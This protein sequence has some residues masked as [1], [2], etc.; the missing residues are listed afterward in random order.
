MI[1]K[2]FGGASCGWTYGSTLANAMAKCQQWGARIVSMSLGGGRSS[3][4]E[5]TQVDAMYTQ[6]NGIL[7]FAAAS[8]DGNSKI[9]YPAG[10][11]NVISVA[12][13]DSS[14]A[15][16]S[17]SNYNSDVELAAPGVQ[18]LSTYP[19]AISPNITTVA[20]AGGISVNTTGTQLGLMEGSPNKG[21]T[22]APID[23]TI[24]SCPN[25]GTGEQHKRQLC[26]LSKL[27][28]DSEQC[29][30]I[31]CWQRACGA[32]SPACIHLY[33]TQQSGS[34]VPAAVLAC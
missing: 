33:V 15:R 21:F 24:N 14:N 28:L 20:V 31:G 18:V 32:A 1:V 9:A 7:L 13:L 29:T 27:L 34:L 17:F 23:C 12:A 6:T 19:L 2:V 30:A 8:N 16:A 10:Y 22:G 5:K 25:P 11:T 26:Q 4:A 3:N